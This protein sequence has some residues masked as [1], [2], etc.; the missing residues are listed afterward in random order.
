[1]SK[2]EYLSIFSPNLV[3]RASFPESSGSIHFQ[4]TMEITGSGSTAQCAV[5][6]YSIYG[7]CLKWMLPKGSCFP[8]TGQGERSSGNEIDFHP[9]WRLLCLLSFKYFATFTVLKIGEHS[10][11]F[12]SFS[13]GIFAHMT[14]LDQSRASEN[15]MDYNTSYLSLQLILRT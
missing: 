5:C 2:D 3:P 15:I 8:T 9:K 12:P 11:I 10:Q 6:I 1:M 7:A 14:R 4:I 13:W